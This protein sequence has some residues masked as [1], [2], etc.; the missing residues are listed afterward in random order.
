MDTHFVAD[1]ICTNYFAIRSSACAPC[2]V[3]QETRSRLGSKQSP[4]DC[5]QVSFL[6]KERPRMLGFWHNNDD[7]DDG[8]MMNS[9]YYYH[10]CHN[11][12]FYQY[13]FIIIDGGYSH[14]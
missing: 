13:L 1:R 4:R 12:Y 3:Q 8:V 2:Y 5:I 11:H 7:G 14:E 6:G 9:S 10:H